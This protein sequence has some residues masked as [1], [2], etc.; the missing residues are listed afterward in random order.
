MKW[1]ESVA[2]L[3][4]CRCIGA[5]AFAVSTALGGP[6]AAQGPPPPRIGVLLPNSPCPP[7]A[8]VHAL[9]EL[10]WVDGRTVT[11]DCRSTHGRFEGVSELVADLVAV[12]PDVL[13]SSTMA[14]APKLK[15]ATATIPIVLLGVS[16]PV[17]MG[18]VRSLARPG[19]NI[20]GLVSVMFDVEEKRLELLK[21]AAPAMK[22]LAVVS[23][24][25]VAPEYDRAI[26]EVVATAARTYGFAYQYFYRGDDGPAL[27]ADIKAK[28]C[29]SIYLVPSPY[30]SET[31]VLFGQL[32]RASHLPAVGF[33]S[34]LADNGLLLTYG[35]KQMSL[36][37]GPEDEVTARRGATYIDKILKGAK[38]GELPMEQPSEFELV[39][40][41]KTAKAAGITIP[42]SLLVRATRVIE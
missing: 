12:H 14:T 9:A 31:T 30:T 10:G 5:L 36:T 40:N 35:P 17:K 6:A 24:R 25:G 11:I 3:W 18:L 37:Y 20:T 8:L 22:Q 38:P 32:A 16:D 41:L 7:T 42:T 34:N 1:R 26:D 13:V 19:G 29:D 33:Y 15:A 27:F 21:E 4:S 28:G 39:I 23:R 2:P